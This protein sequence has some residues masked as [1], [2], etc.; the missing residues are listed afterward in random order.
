MAHLLAPQSPTPDLP[1]F[2]NVDN[3]VGVDPAQN[4]REHV[5]LLQFALQGIGKSPRPSTPPAV[6]E[7]AKRVQTTGKID[8]QTIT[9]I[10][11]IQEDLK[12]NSN[13]SQVVDARVSPARDG[14]SYGAGL[15]TIVFL[16]KAIQVRNG[17]LWPRLDKVPG[18]PP[19]LQRMVR[20]ELVGV[21]V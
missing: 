15:W 12:R 2:F 13:P 20:R 19:D 5:L 21:G 4:L 17:N 16:N 9:T 7:V 6:L 14:Y 3:V 1:V 18:C 8:T 11:L 10:Q